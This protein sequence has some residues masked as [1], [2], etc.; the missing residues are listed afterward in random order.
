MVVHGKH[1]RHKSGKSLDGDATFYR[2]IVISQ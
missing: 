2:V 1:E